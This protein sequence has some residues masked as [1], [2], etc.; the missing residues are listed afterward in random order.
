MPYKS[1]PHDRTEAPAWLKEKVYE[2]KKQRTAT[3]VKA[4][5]D[6]L[7]A[8]NKRISLAAIAAISA[9]VAPEGKGVSESAILTNVEARAY[10]NKHRSWKPPHSCAVAPVTQHAAVPRIKPGRDLNAVRKRYGRRSKTDLVAAL[11]AVEEALVNAE[12]RWLRLNDEL[13]T[14]QLRAE[15]AEDRQARLHNGEEA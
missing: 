5:V 15:T 4:A 3:V 2:V 11:I 6:A 1:E 12:Q 13:L 10:Y 14:W 9:S 7:R 8:V